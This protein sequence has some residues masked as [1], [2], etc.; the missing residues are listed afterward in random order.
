MAKS[1]AAR[2]TK[3]KK[4]KEPRL[5]ILWLVEGKLLIDS[6]PLSESETYADHLI[7]PGSDRHV[8]EQWQKAGNAP[9]RSEYDEYA[10]GR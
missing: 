8:W 7:Y 10:Q 9:A 6:V 5:G 1:A 3:A 4:R 2:M